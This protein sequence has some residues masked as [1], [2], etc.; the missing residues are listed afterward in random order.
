MLTAFIVIAVIGYV[1]AVPSPEKK[2][3]AVVEHHHHHTKVI[4]RPVYVQAQMN[5]VFAEVY[6]KREEM[7]PEPA[8]LPEARLLLKPSTAIERYRSHERKP[9]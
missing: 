2:A 7:K 9:S 4:E 6:L 8:R 1:F 3:T 5:I